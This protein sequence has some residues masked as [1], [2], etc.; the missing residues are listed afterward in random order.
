MTTGRRPSV[1]VGEPAVEV[2][3]KVEVVAPT[4]KSDGVAPNG[5]VVAGFAPNKLVPEIKVII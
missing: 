4:P 3:P 5:A 2:A 1:D